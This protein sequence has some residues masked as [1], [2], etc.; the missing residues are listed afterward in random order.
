MWDFGALIGVKVNGLACTLEVSGLMI[1][2]GAVG[3]ETAGKVRHGA[4]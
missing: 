1:F 4:T 2:A 3:A